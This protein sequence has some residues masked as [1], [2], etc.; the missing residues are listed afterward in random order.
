M[1][2]VLIILILLISVT[3]WYSFFRKRGVSVSKEVTKPH[4][5]RINFGILKSPFLQKLQPFETIPSLE[6]ETA[7]KGEKVKVGRENP[8]V[9]FATGTATKTKVNE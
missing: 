2:W 1:I 3:V 5:I 6:E 4:E 7:K 8:F 9:P